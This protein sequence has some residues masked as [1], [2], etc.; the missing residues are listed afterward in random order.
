MQEAMRNE[1]IRPVQNSDC[2]ETYG[3]EIFGLPK[4]D[5]CT[6]VQISPNV[7]LKNKPNVRLTEAESLTHMEGDPNRPRAP[8]VRSHKSTSRGA[9]PQAKKTVQ[10][11]Q[12]CTGH[13]PVPQC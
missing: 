10:L 4:I 5:F 13:L 3:N 11:E 8:P 2:V 7:G 6:W 9:N 1:T 12:S